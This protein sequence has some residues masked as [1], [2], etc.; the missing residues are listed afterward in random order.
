M[1][2]SL[3]KAFISLA[4]FPVCFF[5]HGC[6]NVPK[7]E[8]T[9]EQQAIEKADRL[10][11]TRAVIQTKYGEIEIMFFPEEAPLH[12]DNFIFLA[13]RG[14]YDGTIFHRVIPGF[15]IQGGDPLT[16]LSDTDRSGYGNG[17]PGY[18]IQG[19]F[20]SISHARGIVSMARGE[21]PNSAGSQFFIVVADSRY[22]D[23]RYT[24]FGKVTRG[25]DAADSI[26]A[27]ARD[28][29]DIPNDRVEMKVMIIEKEKKR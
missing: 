4:L 7:V 20:N 13:Q 9:P 3:R 14:Y 24:V 23:R 26:A 1:P 29:D 28:K 16:R 5:A 17:G 21:D 27:L 25:M 6:V 19:E 2:S 8:Q 10:K 11:R 15:M 22:L 18:A 12:V